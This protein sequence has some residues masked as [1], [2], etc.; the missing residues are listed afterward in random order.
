MI[1]HRG[2]ID[3]GCR[4]DVAQRDVG[5]AAVG[6]KPLGGGKDRGS[7]VI[8]RH[9]MGPMQGGVC[10]SNNCMKL[11]FEGGDCQCAVWRWRPGQPAVV[12]AE[13]RR[14]NDLAEAERRGESAAKVSNIKG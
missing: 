5:K 11:S 4:D 1:I 2:K 10:N 12:P 7:R 14:K 13:S 9:V 8:R 3:A 6:V